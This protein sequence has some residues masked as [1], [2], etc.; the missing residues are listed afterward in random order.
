MRNYARVS[1][2]NGQESH[3]KLCVK[4]FSGKPDEIE[5][6]LRTFLESKVVDIERVLQ[7]ESDGVE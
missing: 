2:R 5:A 7:S 3:N 6:E 1:D 4:M